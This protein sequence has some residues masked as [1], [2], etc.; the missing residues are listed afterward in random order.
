MEE[1]VAKEL[2]GEVNPGML[3]HLRSMSNGLWSCQMLSS[4][5]GGRLFSFPLVSKLKWIAFE[6]P[7][8]AE[9]RI[10]PWDYPLKVRRRSA[11]RYW[12][13][14]VSVTLTSIRLTPTAGCGDPPTAK[15]RAVSARSSRGKTR[16]VMN[17]IC[18]LLCRDLAAGLWTFPLVVVQTVADV[19][20]DPSGV[21]P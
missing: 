12:Y 16:D 14:S 6:L 19:R 13:L 17:A 8:Y 9:I 21:A 1:N 20:F 18:S 3:T 10:E 2:P 4:S 15:V 5:L 11:G 7:F